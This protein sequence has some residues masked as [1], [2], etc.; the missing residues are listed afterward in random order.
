MPRTQK[1]GQAPRALA[2]RTGGLVLPPQPPPRA[3]HDPTSYRSMAAQRA[4]LILD[5]GAD[6]NERLT[7]GNVDW[8][9]MAIAIRR[10]DFPAVTTLL[11]HGADPNARWCVS[12]DEAQ[13]RR[14]RAEGCTLAS[15]MTPLM[16]ASSLGYPQL[17]ALLIEHGADPALRDWRGRTAADYRAAAPRLEPRTRNNRT[18][19][20][21]PRSGN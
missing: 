15:G 5:L 3:G 1:F 17:E 16:A 10:Y 18:S 4:T 8:T 2:G 6:P 12:V 14:V 7:R 20:L 13:A 11:E 9:P 19:N 21:K